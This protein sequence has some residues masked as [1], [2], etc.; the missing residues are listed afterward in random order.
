[1]KI[2][3]IQETVYITYLGKLMASTMHDCSA[4]RRERVPDL[5]VILTPRP[6]GRKS[7]RERRGPALGQLQDRVPTSQVAAF[8]RGANVHDL[9]TVGQCDVK[10]LVALEPMDR[11]VVRFLAYGQIGNLRG[12]FWSA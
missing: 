8:A 4:S 12:R 2:V 5:L 6:Y 1:M 7:A 9:A 10:S 3:R 11:K